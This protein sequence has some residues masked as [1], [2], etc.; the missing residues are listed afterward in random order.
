MTTP[1]TIHRILV[2]TTSPMLEKCAPFFDKLFKYRRGRK[3]VFKVCNSCFEIGVFFL[4]LRDF[5]FERSKLCLHEGQVLLEDRGRSM[6]VDPALDVAEDGY[7]HGV[8]CE[9]G[10]QQAVIQRPNVR[11]KRATAVWRQ[12]READDKQHGLAG[13]AARRWRSA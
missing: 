9:D 1:R 6:F 12:A 13:L 11:A 3:L 4:T 2:P 5:L 10:E 7:S 8:P